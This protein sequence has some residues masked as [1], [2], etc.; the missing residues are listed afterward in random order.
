MSMNSVVRILLLKVWSRGSSTTLP[1]S[2]LEG[3]A[4]GPSSAPLTQNL[5]VSKRPGMYLHIKIPKA[6]V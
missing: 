1:G 5:H 4:V 2:L 3:H 6:L